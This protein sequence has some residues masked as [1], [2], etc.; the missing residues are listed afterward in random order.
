MAVFSFQDQETSIVHLVCFNVFSNNLKLIL[1]CCFFTGNGSCSVDLF[2][3]Y[4]FCA[5]CRIDTIDKAYMRVIIKKTLAL[6]NGHRMRVYFLDV[7]NSLSRQSY[8]V[9]SYP[10]E[11]LSDY[12]QV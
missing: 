8:Q 7:F 5:E 6:E 4:L 1:V 9:M 2:F 11:Y 10:Q 3:C 12:A